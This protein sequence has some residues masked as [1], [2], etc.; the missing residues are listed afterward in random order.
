MSVAALAT[1]KFPVGGKV[2]MFHNRPF[3]AVKLQNFAQILAN[4]ARMLGLR[5]KRPR[6]RQIVLGA[7]SVL[8]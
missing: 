4:R 3:L 7:Y 8:T 5:W 1:G 2:P 6:W